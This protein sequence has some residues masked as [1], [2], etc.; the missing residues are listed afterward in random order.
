MYLS[1]II[2]A[3]NE[4][5]RISKTLFSVH[6]YLS[7]QNYLYEILV[8][9]DGSQDHTVEVV[10]AISHKLSSISILNNIKNRGKGSV[11]RQGMLSAK[12]DICLF[13]DADNSTSID[14]VE[15]CFSWFSQ[16]YDIVIGSLAAE[17]TT[18]SSGEPWYRI[19]LGKLGNKFIQL[20]AVWG[21]HD[22]QR[23]FKVFTRNAVRDI[24][25]KMTIDGWGFDV[26]ILALAQKMGYSIKEI[27]IDWNNQSDSKVSFWAYPEVLWQTVKIRWNLWTGRY[28]I[29]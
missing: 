1:V 26:E 15:R 19:L 17:E 20:V 13:M 9:D 22:T 25:P 21:V 10:Q 28:P 12:G 14:H 6:E 27:P 3:Y 2:P 24:F 18:I 5:K 11:V 7:K 8:I 23:G 29:S 4:E 16:G